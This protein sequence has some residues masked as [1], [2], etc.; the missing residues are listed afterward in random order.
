[1]RSLTSIVENTLLCPVLNDH[2]QWPNTLVDLDIHLDHAR[3]FK[4]EGVVYIHVAC[5]FEDGVPNLYDP[6]LRLRYA[7]NILHAIWFGLIL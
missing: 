7:H 2:C 5:E 3:V 4:S 6:D 1:M